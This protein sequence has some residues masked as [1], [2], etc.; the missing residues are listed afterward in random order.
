M[1][2]SQCATRYRLNEYNFV[3]NIEK[4]NRVTDT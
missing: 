3:E 2:D 4:V 1:W